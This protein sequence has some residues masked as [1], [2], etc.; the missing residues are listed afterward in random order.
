MRGGTL[1]TGGAVSPCTPS[2]HPLP[3]A[4]AVPCTA[5]RCRLQR[6][7]IVP[8]LAHASHAAPSHASVA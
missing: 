6:M 7:C 3:H 4:G 5:L 8:R 1:A 2:T